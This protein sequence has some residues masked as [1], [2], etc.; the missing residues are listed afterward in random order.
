MSYK[1]ERIDNLT[2]RCQTSGSISPSAAE[3]LTFELIAKWVGIPVLFN[4]M[5]GVVKIIHDPWD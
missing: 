1:P 5:T 4:A 2:L 3:G